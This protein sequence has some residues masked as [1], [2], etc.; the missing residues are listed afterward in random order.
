M[1]TTL[2]PNT[3]EQQKTLKTLGINPQLLCEIG[4]RILAAYNQATP[5]DAA[6]AAG[7]FAYFA[8]VKAS[9]DILCPQGWAPLRKHNLEFV[10]QLGR[11]LLLLVSSGDKNT[12]FVGD[13]EPKTKNPKGNQTRKV[14]AKNANQL[15]L[16]PEMEPPEHILDFDSAPA[17]FLL[18]H[19]DPKEGIMRME[20]SLPIGF[21]IEELRVDGWKQ[22]I[23][24]QSIEFNPSPTLPDS[25][26]ADEFE[27]EIRR[28]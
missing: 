10:V 21:D 16:W 6:N 12:G 13:V 22:R 8:A 20:L 2:Q 28:K 5:H 11:N 18:Y 15:Y 24:L 9:R 19:I 25:D 7:S 26:F 3:P 4:T 27:V 1:T 23:I 17:W 14:V